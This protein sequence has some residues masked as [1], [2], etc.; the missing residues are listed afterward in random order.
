MYHDFADRHGGEGNP[1]DDTGIMSYG[2]YDFW[3]STHEWST[4][5]AADFAE[6][7]VAYSWGNW[8]IDDISG[9]LK[10]ILCHYTSHFS[11]NFCLFTISFSFNRG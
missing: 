7:Y 11:P 10:L 4:C 1:C 9:R 5:S 6:H 8:C 3:E 2:T